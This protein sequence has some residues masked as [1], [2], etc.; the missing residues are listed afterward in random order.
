MC[1]YRSVSLGRAILFVFTLV[2]HFRQFIL[3]R[4]G[5]LV[6]SGLWH[7]KLFF[8][9]ITVVYYEKEEKWS[10]ISTLGKLKCRIEASTCAI[11]TI[12]HEKSYT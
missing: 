7:L 12:D 8:L 4:A 10:S 3:Y 6:I 11:Q 2:G 5:Q 1:I 9:L